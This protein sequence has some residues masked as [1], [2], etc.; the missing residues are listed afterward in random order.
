MLGSAGRARA[1]RLT[2]RPGRGQVTALFS[3]YVAALLDEA[4]ANPAGAWQAK[5][6]AIYLV[7]A[8]VRTHTCPPC[9]GCWRLRCWGRAPLYHSL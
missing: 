2:G 6:C 9:A 5:D 3:G 7:T 8:L 4:A 1:T